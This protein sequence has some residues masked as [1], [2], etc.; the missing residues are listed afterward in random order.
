MKI[1]IYNYNIIASNLKHAGG[2]DDHQQVLA[3][4]MI[5]EIGVKTYNFNNYQINTYYVN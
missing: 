1:L 3:Y 5:T 2:Y 4:G